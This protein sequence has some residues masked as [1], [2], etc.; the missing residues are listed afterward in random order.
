MRR[1][2]S[3]YMHRGHSLDEENHCVLRNS[4]DGRSENI[5]LQKKGRLA[6]EVYRI[7]TDQNQNQTPQPSLHDHT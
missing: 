6:Q 7:Q 1:F 2:G 3:R 4:C 5:E